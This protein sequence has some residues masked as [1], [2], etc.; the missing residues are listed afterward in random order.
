MKRGF[1]SSPDSQLIFIL[2]LNLGKKRE[3]LNVSLT[4]N[5]LFIFFNENSGVVWQ[6]SRS[7]HAHTHRHTRASLKQAYEKN[8]ECLEVFFQLQLNKNVLIKVLGKQS[9]C[10]QDVAAHIPG[11]PAWCEGGRKGRKP[12]WGPSPSPPPQHNTQ[13]GFL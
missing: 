3:K 9:L 2:V 7:A 8:L 13:D 6:K 5:N 11:R 4:H 12:K 10:Q 1:T